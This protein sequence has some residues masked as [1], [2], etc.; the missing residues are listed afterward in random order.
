[1]V[2]M[3]DFLA[4]AGNPHRQY[5]AVQVA[6]TSG[7][8]SVTVM[9]AA[10]LG[11]CG[12]RTG[13]HTSPY[14]QLCNEKL[15]VDDVMVS[16]AGFTKLI[17]QFREVYGEWVAGNGRFSRLKYGEAWIALTYIWLAKQKVDWAVVETGMGGR[18]DPISVLPAKLAIVTNIGFDHVKSLGPALTDIAYHKAGI[19]KEGQ[20]AVTAVADPAVLRVIQDE[21]AKKR[22]TLYC[23]GQDFS[24]TVE[25]NA[26]GNPR[27]TVQTPWNKYDGIIVPGNSAYQFENGAVAVTAVDILAQHHNIPIT[28]AAVRSGMA[29]LLFPGRMEMMQHAPLVM[30]DGA[31]NPHKIQ[32]LVKSVLAL[33]PDKKISLLVG[34]IMGKNAEAMLESLLPIAS[35]IIATQPHVFGKPSYTPEQIAA[36]IHNLNPQMPVQAMPDAQTAINA[37]LPT[38]GEDDLLLI[39]GSLYLV[40]EARDFWH[41]RDKILRSLMR[42]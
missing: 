17:G 2:R 21:A 13:H 32:A 4:F 10:I 35:R 28:P 34:M 14:L 19:I 41:P 16:P 33:Y 38:L 30:L 7:K 6:G 42:P 39:T 18:Y 37:I 9:T 36:F 11:A 40:G 12:L 31:H 22:A 1:M 27:L 29:D 26:D 15:V 3:A 8:G 25:T 5:P 20:L 24:Y 23:L